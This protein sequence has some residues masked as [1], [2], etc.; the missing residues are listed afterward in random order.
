MAKPTIPSGPR[1]A[2]SID[3]TCAALGGVS[4]DWLYRRI[5]DGTIRTIKLAGRRFVPRSEFERIA[6]GVSE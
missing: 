2:Y 3:E 4:R 1:A 5:N 6:A